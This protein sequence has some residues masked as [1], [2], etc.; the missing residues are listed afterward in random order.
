ML[1]SKYGPAS[2]ILNSLLQLGVT[3]ALDDFGT[4]FSSLT[5]LLKLPYTRIK[6]DQSFIREHADTAG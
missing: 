1:I 4:G 3:V 6:I 5:Y 2:S